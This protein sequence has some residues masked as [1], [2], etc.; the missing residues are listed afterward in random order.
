MGNSDQYSEAMSDAVF[1]RLLD[2]RT[3][4]LRSEVDDVVASRV[5]SQLVL[6]GSED[7]AADI[8]LYIASPGGNV[9]SA[10]AIHD[11]MHFVSCDVSTWAVG[12]VGSVGNLILSSGSSGKRYATSTSLMSL[13]WSADARNLDPS[14]RARW[15]AEGVRTTARQTGQRMERV[16]VDLCKGH[17]LTAVGAK[18]YGLV[19]AV[20][21][22][23]PGGP[24][25]N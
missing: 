14:S 24:Q 7:P 11:A 20:V 9:P 19:D 3:V 2:L 6:L 16:A 17:V 4:V 5:V 13:D 21:D 23:A 15:L 8:R 10:L 18:S 1:A 25:S 22:M 12:Y